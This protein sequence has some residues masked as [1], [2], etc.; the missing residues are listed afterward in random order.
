MIG[1]IFLTIAFLA[2]LFSVLMYGLSVKGYKNTDRYGRLGFYLLSVFVIGASIILFNAIITHQYQYRYVYEY[3]GSGLSTGLLLS[4]F[5]AGQE[6]SFLLWNLFASIIGLVLIGY[7]SKR[8]YNEGSVMFF[9][10]LTT[11][12][13]L[14][15]VSPLLKT[16]FAYLWNSVA[17][18]DLN[19]INKHLVSLPYLREFIFTDSQTGNSF[20]KMSSELYGV[21]KGANISFNQFLIQGKGLNPLLQN[22]WMQIHPPILFV[23]FALSAVPFS[24]AMSALVKRDYKKWLKF[25][26]P[27]NLIGA[28]VLGASI[29]LGGYWAYGVLGWGG[30]W[31]W[32]PVENASLVP[33]LIWVALIHTMLI[34]GRSEREGKIA[35]LKTNLMLSA[36]VFV[37]VIYSTFLTRSGILQDASVHSFAVPGR[38]VFTFLLVFLILFLVIPIYLLIKNKND[39]ETIKLQSFRILSKESFLFY[40]SVILIASAIVII[41]GT[42]MPIIGNA[43]DISFYNDMN[44]PIAILLGLTNSISI[45]LKWEKNSTKKFFNSIILSF[46]SAL[47]FTI[48]TVIFSEI[49]TTGN[50]ILL[51]VSWFTITTNL[52]FIFTVFKKNVKQT[53]AYFSHLGVG[54]FL[55]GVI[56]TGN[57]VE[58]TQVDLQK[59]E[60]QKIL[61]HQIIFK[62]YSLIPN[63]NKY[64]FTLLIDDKLEAYPVMYFSE[65]NNGIMKE[66]Y[67]I[68]RFTYDYYITPLGFETKKEKVSGEKITLKKQTSQIVNDVEIFFDSF[69][70]PQNAFEAMQKGKEFVIGVNLI[71][72]S[73]GNEIKIK[74]VMKTKGNERKFIPVKVP[75]LKLKIQLEW[76]D[77]SGSVG[78]IVAKDSNETRIEKQN[79]ILT[80]EVRIEPFISLIWIGTI[81]I[82]LGFIIAYFK[83]KNNS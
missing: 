66:P 63:T 48:G 36:L 11:T 43:I 70:F 42:S 32:D 60:P 57:F 12:F 38:I 58:K 28:M 2:S 29:M 69:D 74:P 52:E 79:D 67:I 24:F 46:V 17:Y 30:Y 13:L 34:Q 1:N 81:F 7:L 8:N 53:G 37:L 19:N 59:N 62:D 9:Y 76:L 14:A 68:S 78:L 21:L 41:A 5:Y 51:F 47:L 73:G 15:M 16:P 77:A 40:G 27:W 6:G 31:G 10:S 61:G 56:F 23:G 20:V 50:I 26:M 54:I 65:Y 4:T 72:K 3:S 83:R 82:I 55:I 22:F 71:L 18:L 33:W 45:Y 35:F 25:S 49:S 75:E 64:K 44:F 80:I 39:F